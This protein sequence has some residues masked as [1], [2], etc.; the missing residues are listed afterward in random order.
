MA[1]QSERSLPAPGR[2][3][4]GVPRPY[5][6]TVD[7]YPEGAA[8]ALLCDG[9][10]VLLDVFA[11][12]HAPAS[13]RA[14]AAA[15]VAAF[16]PREPLDPGREE[17][18]RI[19]LLELALVDGIAENPVF[20]GLR[21][22]LIEALPR[23]R[24]AA[25]AVVDAGFSAD[26]A[27]EDQSRKDLDQPRGILAFLR[28]P[29][30]AG[31]DAEAQLAWFCDR[32]R[33]LAELPQFRTFFR[34]VAE[35]REAR[36]AEIRRYE[37]HHPG[38]APAELPDLSGFSGGFF[39]GHEASAEPS[40]FDAE[41]NRRTP[42]PEPEVNYTQDR[43]WMP[44]VVILAKAIYV[45]LDQLTRSYGYP[46]QQLNQI[47]DAELDALRGRGITGLWMIG[48]WERSPAS[49][50]I[51]AHGRHPDDVEIAA[52]AYS[53]KDYTVAEALG[54]ERALE[55]LRQRAK[56][57][58]IRLCGDVV[59]NH[60]GLDS[61]WMHEHPE[62][63]LQAARPPYKNYRFTGP[64]LGDAQIG[65]RLEDGYADRSDAAVVF[66]YRNKT[67]NQIR[68]IYHGNDGTSTPWN[69]TAQIDI[70]NPEA[71][72]ALL[73]TIVDVAKQ[74]PILR[75]DAAMTLAKR[76]VRRLWHPRIGDA[77][78][79][80]SRGEH[81]MSDARFEQLLPREFWR[82][83]VD[84]IATEAPDTL[85]LAEAFWM[86]EGYFVR[87]LGMHRVY[88]SAF[89]HMLKQEDNGGYRAFLKEILAHAP[90]TLGRFVHFMNNPDEEPA[91]EQFGTFEKYFGV[92]TLVATL[93]GLPLF[94]HGQFEG[95]R[96]KYGMEYLKAR[97]EEPIDQG[98][99]K[100]HERVI[101][102]LL[103]ERARFAGV[104]N[105]RLYD[106]IREDGSVDPDVYAFTQRDG[107]TRSVIF[108]RNSP[109]PAVFGTIHQSAPFLRD[110]RLHSETIGEALAVSGDATITF[111]DPLRGVCLAT[112]GN[113]LRFAGFPVALGPYETLVFLELHDGTYEEP[114][115][116]AA[117]GDVDGREDH[118]TL[119]S[120]DGADEVLESGA[121]P[122]RDE[123]VGLR[124]AKSRIGG[125]VGL[126][127][128]KRQIGEQ[129]E[130]LALVDGEETEA[131]SE[132]P[133]TRD[134]ATIVEA[135]EEPDEP[136]P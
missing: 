77:G 104:A 94:G 96:E 112:S 93:P 100:E 116:P 125:H 66:E 99:L 108:Y 128:A 60:T 83:V 50:A 91:A 53:L 2:A 81:P 120:D 14:A 71:R 6:R 115:A 107:A 32:W 18:R 106:F 11:P 111:R 114:E 19:A 5:G 48:L 39:G 82:D 135:P 101:F 54:G 127:P 119:P 67:T 122:G 26:D 126:R 38:P 109:R 45:W 36:A 134:A 130:K 56:I 79:V 24:D 117:A 75:F 73:Q 90:E 9:F 13:T 23:D 1:P 49:K 37:Q 88:N 34:H 74:F 51:K 27:P 20:S 89:M 85:L 35:H 61:R 80:P 76:H 129:T 28:S 86:M 59:P 124:P 118:A 103:R 136:L 121:S 84:R 22:P 8:A 52:S 70:L 31:A 95:F 68:Y 110:G 72:E 47:P 55:E 17:D 63:F 102:P 16:P 40:P 46:I 97:R 57:R 41:G 62:W 58:G 78:G 3:Y 98:L 33:P 4:R 92:C 69:D 21:A 30:V 43:D 25:L 12:R 7:G 64:D 65:I 15:T 105:F 10:R 42:E 113:E 132:E 133:P 131:L 87:T 44:E 29:L 123:E